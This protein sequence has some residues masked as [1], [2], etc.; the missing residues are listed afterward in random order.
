[1]MHHP[2]VSKAPRR[3][4]AP[5]PLESRIA[6]AFL[7][8][9]VGATATI[10]DSGDATNH[11]FVI[12]DNGGVL[13]VTVDAVPLVPT[14][15]PTL[16]GI[17]TIAFTHT[18]GAAGRDTVTVDPT[19]LSAALDG[20]T[21][22]FD[23]SGGPSAD[24]FNAATVGVGAVTFTGGTGADLFFSGGGTTTATGGGGADTLTAANTNNT[25]TITG[26]GTGTIANNV[27]ANLVSFSG[28]SN[29]VGGT[30]ADTFTLS[31]GTLT[32]SINGGTGT[33]TLI[34]DNVV[35][36]WVVGIS[37]KLPSRRTR[38]AITAIAMSAQAS[39]AGA[40]AAKKSPIFMVNI[41]AARRS[42]GRLTSG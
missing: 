38:T 13:R 20:K 29:L 15:D 27:N 19:N 26:A 14:G 4:P 1:M 28:I 21:Y 25:W 30:G 36:T 17:T 42:G 22:T 23:A 7:F 31:G 32:G 37:L 12:D 2:F 5:E 9:I 39:N 10:S 34:G 41:L 35:T 18:A 33:D 24:S 6:P 8:N 3:N 40:S 16:A 11:S